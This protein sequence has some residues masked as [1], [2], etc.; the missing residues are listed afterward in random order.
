VIRTRVGYAGGEIADPTYYRIGDHIETVQVDYDPSRISYNELLDL[1][2]EVASLMKPF[3]RQY[4]SAIYYANDE[5]KLL[6]EESLQVKADELN[7][8]IYIELISL[9][10]FY[11]AEDYHQKYYLKSSPVIYKDFQSIYTSETDLMNSTSAARVN[12]FLGGNGTRELLD[13][14]LASYGL[15]S[16]GESVLLEIGNRIFPDGGDKTCSIFRLPAN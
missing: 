14:E 1:Y 7:Q 8:E 6:A 5:Q 15:S 11:L 2:W 16:K 9:D 3:S 12:G 4:T 10:R 13:G